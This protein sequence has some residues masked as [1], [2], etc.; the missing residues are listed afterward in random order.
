MGEQQWCGGAPRVGVVNTSPRAPSG[1]VYTLD[2]LAPLRQPGLGV[3]QM[4][5]QPRQS[6]GSLL[7]AR[8]GALA[9][10]LVRAIAAV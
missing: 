5:L 1:R 8:V 4:S 3:G 2:V 10:G 9:R 7:F 6:F